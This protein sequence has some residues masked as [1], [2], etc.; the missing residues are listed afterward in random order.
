MPP[1]QDRGGDE[2]D[3]QWPAKVGE[4]FRQAENEPGGQ[5]GAGSRVEKQAARRID[6]IGGVAGPRAVQGGVL[7]QAVIGPAVAPTM[8]PVMRFVY[9]SEHAIIH[10]DLPQIHNVGY[11]IS[12][13]FFHPGD[14]FTDPGREVEILAV[15]AGA[16][17][18]KISEAI[19]YLRALRPAHAI[20]VHDRVLAHPSST[21]RM[22]A[23]LG[24]PG[25][26]LT[27]LVPDATLQIPN[28]G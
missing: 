7:A 26:K 24:P 11:L 14:A 3:D 4:L 28:T 25:T 15:P 18:M 8:G 5:G 9:G 2:D 27:P 22:L 21:F 20:P 19:D 16:P 23:D 12:D 17:W 1:E 13:R 6:V 10:P